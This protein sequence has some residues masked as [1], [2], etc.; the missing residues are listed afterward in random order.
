MCG[1]ISR[2][3][4]YEQDIRTGSYDSPFEHPGKDP[5]FWHDTVSGLIIDRAAVVA[6]LADLGD[7]QEC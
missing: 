2:L 6:L 1:E 3:R 4:S 5:F 7:L